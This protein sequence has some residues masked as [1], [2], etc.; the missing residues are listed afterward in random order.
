MRRNYIYVGVWWRPQRAPLAL[1]EPD[2]WHTTLLRCNLTLPSHQLAQWMATHGARINI[3]MNALLRA[4][5][6]V[7]NADNTITVWL[8]PPPWPKSW[9]FGVPSN[10]ATALMPL[11]DMTR[12]SIL[13]VDPGADVDLD[14]TDSD[15][16]HIS[17]K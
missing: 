14:V 16:F 1:L 9:T 12:R 3:L 11:C 13:A 4:L 6:F 10:V 15:G 7:R 8:L 5:T 17:W 2:L